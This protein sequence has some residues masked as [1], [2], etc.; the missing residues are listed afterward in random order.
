MHGL[1]IPAIFVLL[2]L[3]VILLCVPQRQRATAAKEYVS[4]AALL[5]F[6]HRFGEDIIAVIVMAGAFCVGHLGKTGSLCSA[7][8]L[9]FIGFVVWAAK[10]DF[11]ENREIR[12]GSVSAFNARVETYVRAGR[13]REKAIEITTRIRDG[14]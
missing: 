12:G 4:V 14:K 3:I 8:L 6:F 11:R 5:L 9:V 2:I 13:T 1:E 7:C 10:K